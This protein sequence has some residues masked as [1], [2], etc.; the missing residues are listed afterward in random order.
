M[1]L[2]YTTKI[3]DGQCHVGYMVPGT[4]VFS[5]V[6]T[7]C[8]NPRSAQVLADEMNRMAQAET[9]NYVPPEDRKIIPGF[10]TDGDAG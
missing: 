7:G 5:S 4:N 10:Y 6:C 9:P 8:M 2:H 3:F 1:P